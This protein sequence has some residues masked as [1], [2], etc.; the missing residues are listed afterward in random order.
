MSVL[1][2]AASRGDLDSCA[3]LLEAGSDVNQ[4][5]AHH[6]SALFYAANGGFIDCVEMLIQAGAAIDEVDQEGTTSLQ[7]AVINSNFEMAELLLSNG[8]STNVRESRQLTCMHFCA[9]SGNI[10]IGKLLQ[11]HGASLDESDQ[12]FRTPLHWAVCQKQ[13]DFARWL[14]AEGARI[15]ACDKKGRTPLI[16]AALTQ[17]LRIVVCLVEFGADLHVKDAEARSAFDIA[18]SQKFYECAE[19]LTHMSNSSTIASPTATESRRRSLS[20]H[21]PP[22]SNKQAIR[23]KR[24]GGLG[25]SSSPT[26]SSSSPQSKENVEFASPTTTGKTTSEKSS[27]AE[28][29]AQINAVLTAEIKR[30][31]R[32][33]AETQAL[34]RQLSSE[35][36]REKQIAVLTALLQA[37]QSRTKHYAGLITRMSSGKSAEPIAVSSKPSLVRRT[38]DTKAQEIENKR[39]HEQEQATIRELQQLTQTLETQ[40]GLLKSC[41]QENLELKR[42]LGEHFRTPAQLLEQVAMRKDSQTRMAQLKKDVAQLRTDLSAVH[43]TVTSWQSTSRQQIEAVRAAVWQMHERKNGKGIQAMRL[44]K[45]V[46]EERKQLWNQLQDLKG[47]IRVFCRIRPA[48]SSS[49]AVAVAPSKVHEGQVTVVHA[50]KKRRFE[51]D[52]VFGPRATQ[53]DVFEDTKPLI[54]SVVDGFNVCIFA[55]GQT[56]SGKTHTMQG[57]PASPG[58]MVRALH[59]L[60]ALTQNRL[61]E[62][63]SYTIDVSIVEIYNEKVYCLLNKDQNRSASL[64]VRQSTDGRGME[65]ADAL[66]VPVSSADDIESVLALGAQNRSTGTT[67]LNEHSSRSHLLLLIRVDG[68]NRVTGE[69]NVGKL[70]LVD[71]AGSERID[72]A[73]TSGSS[74]KETVAINASLSALGAVISAL[75]RKEAH[76]PYRN[77]K[78]TFLLQDSIG[79]GSSKTLMFMQVDSRATNASESVLSLQFAERARSVQLAP[80]AATRRPAAASSATVSSATRS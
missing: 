58:V 68:A 56:G 54:R 61:A 69:R 80:Q 10:E 60:F 26:A 49:D 51:F 59:E 47:A 22:P 31:Q 13:E 74:A 27:E 78:L 67:N 8:A 63:Y 40:Q 3:K 12:D 15:D 34:H 50:A 46:L 72:K 66:R 14:L 7:K 42:Q 11:R 65:V 64:E 71:L 23:A 53:E 45:Q 9:H 79:A 29:E 4:L 55:Y 52:R 41:E 28:L 57:T 48:T 35:G 32:E 62:G 77:S 33:I 39:L 17:E 21:T 25:T 76:V 18:K 19:Y 43:S 20:A 44:Y 6:R 75:Q 36:D 73:G 37:E 16:Y 30:T 70:T 38:V 24:R 1:S 2:V 5:D